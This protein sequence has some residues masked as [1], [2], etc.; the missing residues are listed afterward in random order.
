MPLYFSTGVWILFHEQNHSY[1][2]IHI[3]SPITHRRKLV[4]I[5]LYFEFGLVIRRSAV[6]GHRWFSKYSSSANY[7]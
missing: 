7:I 2:V 5:E 4:I 6:R 3:H 1:V